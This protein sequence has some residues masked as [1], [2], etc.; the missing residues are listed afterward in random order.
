VYNFLVT[1][2]EGAW[3]S[4][5]EYDKSRF[6]EYTNDDIAASF[7]ELKEP[8]LQALMELPCLFAYEGTQHT[9]RVGK[10]EVKLRRDGKILFARPI[11][12]ER[13]APIEFA[14]IK[15]HQ[16]ALDI[17]DWEINRTHWAVKDEDLFAIL[18]R[19]GILPEGMVGSKVTK[20]DLPA[21][22]PPETQADSVGA[23]IEHVFRLNHGRRE[24]FI[25]GTRTAK[26]IAWNPRFFAGIK[27]VTSYT[28]M[29]KI[30]CIGNF[31]FPIP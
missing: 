31:W 23:F 10:V 5:Y 14:Q 1:S 29:L 18:H 16:A 24:V 6:L 13:I 9:M 28:E 7:K 15:P 19:A 3:E 26:S 4:G 25:E 20:E 11:I 27:M 21:T 2:R 17:R 8:Q 22:S 30:G 12:D